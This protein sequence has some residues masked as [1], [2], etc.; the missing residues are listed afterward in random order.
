MDLL[1]TLTPPEGLLRIADMGDLFAETIDAKRAVRK[2]TKALRIDTSPNPRDRYLSADDQILAAWLDIIDD[3]DG[4]GDGPVS[5]NRIEACVMRLADNG[6]SR[7]AVLQAFLNA[8]RVE[9]GL[10]ALQNAA[11]GAANP[12]L[13]PWQ[14]RLARTGRLVL[15]SPTALHGLSSSLGTKRHVVAISGGSLVTFDLSPMPFS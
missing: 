4:R 8:R 12:R 6:D 7:S 9:G 14:S 13:K 10:V 1:Q 3:G 15:S 2:F 11:R 5:R